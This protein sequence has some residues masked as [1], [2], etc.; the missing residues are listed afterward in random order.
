MPRSSS[1]TETS[2]HPPANAIKKPSHVSRAEKFLCGA[3]P[4]FDRAS[5]QIEYNEGGYWNTALGIV[6]DLR[7]FLDKNPIGEDVVRITLKC[8]VHESKTSMR[9]HDNT[10]EAAFPRKMLEVPSIKDPLGADAAGGEAPP[11]IAP[12]ALLSQRNVSND[13]LKLVRSWIR[14]HEKNNVFLSDSSFDTDRY[15]VTKH[16]RYHLDDEVWGQEG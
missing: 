6:R 16:Y 13:D 7:E 11:M 9:S 8:R 15:Y 4:L 5:D 3:R 1:D 10:I 12:Y 14:H 2:D